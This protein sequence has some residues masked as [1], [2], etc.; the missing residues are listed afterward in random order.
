[1]AILHEPSVMYNPRPTPDDPHHKDLLAR[2]RAY[3]E[4]RG[5]HGDD[6]TYHDKLDKS[7]VDVL[8]RCNNPTAL[9]IRTRADRFVVRGDLNI[10]F[11]LEAKSTQGPNL[12]V[13]ALPFAVHHTDYYLYGVRCLYVIGHSDAGE[14]GFWAGEEDPTYYVES[15]TIP[16]WRHAEVEALTLEAMFARALPGVPIILNPNSRGS[17]DPYVKIPVDYLRKLRHWQDLIDDALD[18]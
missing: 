13:E 7:L 1:M 5:L 12:V 16:T 4:S 14:R 18:V 8:A 15:I 2:A 9:Y 3:C 17:G 10:T 6:L 11:T